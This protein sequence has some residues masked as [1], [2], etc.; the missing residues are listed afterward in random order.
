[1]ILVP[2]LFFLLPLVAGAMVRVIQPSA[3][4][5]RLLLSFSGAF[6]LGVVFLHMLPELYEEEGAGI[7]LW[8]LAGFLFQ[9]V[10]EFFSHGIEHGHIHLHGARG[11]ALPLATLISLCLH[12][13]TEGM[14]FADPA[15]AGNMPFLL[16]VLLHKMPMAIALAAVLQR[17]GGTGWSGWFMLVIFALAA[18][19]GILVGDLARGAMDGH[20]LHRMLGLA[21]GMLLHISTTIIFESAPEH[22]FNAARFAAV[23]VGAAIAL[24]LV[25]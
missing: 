6:L 17:S 15:V 23:I 9:V 3:P 14:P 24:L 4:W 10:L 13:F 22:R 2:V 19:A 1:M 7:G 16:G 11:L 18:P 25:H 20:L 5:L 8:L 21:I 12:S